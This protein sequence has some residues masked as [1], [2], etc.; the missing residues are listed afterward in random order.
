MKLRAVEAQILES[1]KAGLDIKSIREQISAKPRTFRSTISR[2]V[3]LGVL[4]KKNKGMYGVQIEQYVVGPDDEILEERRR[5]SQEHMQPLIPL[6]GSNAEVIIM[7]NYNRVPRSQ[8]L[9]LLH[10]SGYRMTKF[11]MNILI[12]KIQGM[13]IDLDPISA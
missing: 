5:A 13:T 4:V 6:A 2:M 3:E 8:L 7:L 11:Q 12:M 10:K 1:L 9:K